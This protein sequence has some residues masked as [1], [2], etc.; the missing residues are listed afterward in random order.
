MS[1]YMD[2]RPLPS[3]VSLDQVAKV[4]SRIEQMSKGIPRPRKRWGADRHSDRITVVE[5]DRRDRTTLHTALVI[6][7]S[8]IVD[9]LKSSDAE[10]ASVETYFNNVAVRGIWAEFYHQGNWYML[11]ASRIDLPTR[12][13]AEDLE[14]IADE[15]LLQQGHTRGRR[16]SVR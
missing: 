3:S 6:P 10:Q 7:V 2:G 11:S 14:R 9:A 4:A 15:F 13:R 16:K 1:R 5:L 12:A 8:S